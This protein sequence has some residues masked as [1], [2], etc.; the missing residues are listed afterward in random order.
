MKNY[1]EIYFELLKTTSLT[2][3]SRYLY[4]IALK[5]LPPL[6]MSPINLEES[7]S[8]ILIYGRVYLYLL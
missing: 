5:L 4:Y 3:L 1:F 7:L 8:E 6:K 2:Q